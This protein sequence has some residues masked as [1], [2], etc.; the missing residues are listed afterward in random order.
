MV[1]VDLSVLP[2]SLK[3]VLR[4]IFFRGATDGHSSSQHLNSVLISFA[5]CIAIKHIFLFIR[6]T[7]ST[8]ASFKTHFPQARLNILNLD[9]AYAILEGIGDT[10]V[11]FPVYFEG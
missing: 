7:A 8:A 6:I 4:D 3:I 11:K 5:I 1:L 9:I 2:D 10:A